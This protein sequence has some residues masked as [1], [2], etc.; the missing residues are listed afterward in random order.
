MMEH[1][2][3]RKKGDLEMK[4]IERKIL[5]FWIVELVLVIEVAVALGGGDE[6]SKS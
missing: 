6:E 3:R 2:P 5:F 1:Y 4:S